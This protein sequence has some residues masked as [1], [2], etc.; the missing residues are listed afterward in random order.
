M[1]KLLSDRISVTLPTD[2]SADRYQ[3]LRPSEVE[4]NLGVPAANN[5]VLVSNISGERFWSS[6]LNV[7]A[8]NAYYLN[9]YTWSSP[10]IIGDGL[11]NSAIFTTV[12]V[13]ADLTVNSNAMIE[14][15]VELNS[16][17]HT[18]SR[19]ITTETIMQTV[20]AEFPAS[21]YRGGK[22]IIQVHKTSENITTISEFLLVHDGTNTYSTEYGIVSTG[23]SMPLASY[24]TNI[25]GGNIR[26]LATPITS[27]ELVFKITETLFLV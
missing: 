9:G 25:A 19:T 26:F 5:S 1:F 20:I 8:N 4:P 12:T 21:T 14:G 18:S 22:I 11:S 27:D 13:G 15:Y 3:F 7:S 17:S 16:V 6:D 10:S 2:V 24:E 23:N